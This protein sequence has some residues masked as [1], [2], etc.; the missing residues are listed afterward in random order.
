MW[1]LVNSNIDFLFSVLRD[2]TSVLLDQKLIIQLMNPHPCQHI[3]SAQQC[4]ILLTDIACCSLM[5]LDMTSM[6]KLWDLIVMLFK[7]QLCL[8]K[9][10]P[11]QLLDLTFRHM[12]GISKL[13]PE[14]KKT[15]LVDCTKRSLIEFWDLC[16]EDDKNDLVLKLWHWMHPFNVK[17]SILIRLGFQRNDGTFETIPN[18]LY[19]EHF[20]DYRD[21]VGEN[22]YAKNNSVIKP[23]TSNKKFHE[24]ERLEDRNRSVDISNE[25][26]T[27]ATQ[28]NVNHDVETEHINESVNSNDSGEQSNTSDSNEKNNILLIDDVN[29]SMSSDVQATKTE[30][31]TPSNAA[32]SE[33]IHLKQ[34]QSALQGYLEQFRLENEQGLVDGTD[35]ANSFDA[36]EE[37]LKM[38]DK[39]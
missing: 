13:L 10:N 5:R 38:L 17:I 29:C 18:Q 15:L 1:F 35:A 21:N 3:L 27:F 22:V 34:T 25:L 32:N 23:K 14:M 36:T 33:F 28:L 19:T 31:K 20:Q 30:T 2:L 37:L 39:E 6:D 24:I 8:I 26:S 4:R 7:W 12:D 9:N 16:T 11:N